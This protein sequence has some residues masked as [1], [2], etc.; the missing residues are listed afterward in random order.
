MRAL[1]E[2]LSQNA[3]SVFRW[4]EHENTILKHIVE[5]LQSRDDVPA[6]KEELIVFLQT[7]IKG[8]SRAMIDLKELAQKGYFHPSTKGSNSIKK[9]LPAVLESSAFLKERYSQPIYGTPNGILSTNFRNMIWWSADKLGLVEDPYKKLMGEM[10][11]EWVVYE[12]SDGDLD[13]AAGGEATMAYG[14]LQYET[15]DGQTRTSLKAKLLRY[16]ELDTLAMAMVVEAWKDALP[17]V[18][19]V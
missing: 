2:A 16:C 12:A 3:G 13:I 4:A 15:L 8:G 5:Q 6:D 11:G 17:P 19:R 18:H 7:L 14:R 1:K 9:V 10:S